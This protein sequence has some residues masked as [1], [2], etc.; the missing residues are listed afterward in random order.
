[1][2]AIYFVSY[3]VRNIHLCLR[4]MVC[5]HLNKPIRHYGDI[6]DMARMIQSDLEPSIGKS[7]VTILNYKRL[8]EEA[9]VENSLEENI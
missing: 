1:M 7:V 9:P 6:Q 4:D 2:K 8:E 3:E 5:I